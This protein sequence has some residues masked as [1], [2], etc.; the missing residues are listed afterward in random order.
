MKKKQWCRLIVRLTVNE[1]LRFPPCDILSDFNYMQDHH[2]ML[3]LW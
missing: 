2:D 3:G 1:R